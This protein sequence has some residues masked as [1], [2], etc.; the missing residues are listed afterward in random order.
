MTS[1]KSRFGRGGQEAEEA[2]EAAAATGK[3]GGFRRTH[4]LPKMD[5]NDQI[6]LRYLTD[7]PEWYYVMSHASAPT[8]AKPDNWPSNNWPESM[9]AICRY[10]KAF[11]ADPGSGLEAV[12]HDCYICDAGLVNQWGRPCKATQ[13]LYALAVRREPVLGTDEMVAQGLIQEHQ[14]GKRVGFRDAT[15]EVEVPKRDEK[16][17]VVKDSEGKVV[18]EK[19]TE[20]DI[21]VINQAMNN[22]FSS[23]QS[24]YNAYGTVCDRD[25]VVTRKGEGKDTDY[26][27]VP[28]DKI[29]SHVPG[30]DSWKVYEEAVK[31]QGDSVDIEKIL[32]E[33]SSDDYFARFFDP[34]KEAPLPGNSN[35]GDKPSGEQAS[36]QSGQSP[37]LAKEPESNAG[38]DISQ[39]KLREMRERI[40]G[41]A[42][43]KSDESAEKSG[44]LNF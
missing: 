39:D 26:P 12:Y 35:G 9:S 4:Y 6:F 18:L 14:V 28:L 3:G 5:K 8:K 43:T 11:Q 13:R 38:N 34:N 1:T 24:A 29:D 42:A 2:A 20:L 22:Y 36:S 21:L 10:D 31:E 7:S 33:R 16:G 15:R 17:E 40:R 23:L 30:S 27:H 32:E 37:S 41:G 44:A 25:Y 19:T